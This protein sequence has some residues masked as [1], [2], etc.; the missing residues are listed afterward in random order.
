ME[1]LNCLN[2]DPENEDF[3]FAQ[4]ARHAQKQADLDIAHQEADAIL[5]QPAL[6]EQE[7]GGAAYSENS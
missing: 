6:V 1:N 7:N 5:E 2:Y 3:I 4:L